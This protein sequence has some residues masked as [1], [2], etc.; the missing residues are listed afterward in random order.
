MK[1]YAKAKKVRVNGMDQII[2]RFR[3]VMQDHKGVEKVYIRW[4]SC[5]D[6]AVQALANQYGWEYEADGLTA[7]AQDDY[8]KGRLKI[9]VPNRE[10][11]V[12]WAGSE[13]HFF[14]CPVEAYQRD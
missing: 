10:L 1:A 2:Y 8:C 11:R 5:A 14:S 9:W 7:Y 6:N 4:A 3:I 13:G 12:K